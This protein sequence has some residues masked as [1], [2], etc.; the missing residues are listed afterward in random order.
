M[1]GI[2]LSIPTLELSSGVETITRTFLSGDTVVAPRAVT[3]YLTMTMTKENDFFLSSDM[4]KQ[5]ILGKEL[6]TAIFDCADINIEIGPDNVKTIIRLSSKEG[7]TYKF[8][9]M[10]PAITL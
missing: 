9:V 8:A 10:T 1:K 7:M 2:A 6:L 4:Y 3:Q 5:T